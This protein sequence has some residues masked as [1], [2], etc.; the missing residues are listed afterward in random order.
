MA[1]NSTTDE[2]DG[3]VMF[4]S[5]GE[6]GAVLGS[7][8]RRN[9]YESQEGVMA[10]TSDRPEVKMVRTGNLNLLSSK[11]EVCASFDTFEKSFSVENLY[12]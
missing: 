6:D 11:F 9:S 8:R 12:T 1:I 4:R 5:V 2:E 3:G 10:S 7:L